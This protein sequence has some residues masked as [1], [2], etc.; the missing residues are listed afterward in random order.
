MLEITIELA[1]LSAAAA[2]ALT[3]QV[4]PTT[5]K[6]FAVSLGHLAITIRALRTG[7]QSFAG[8]TV[9]DF[10][11]RTVPAAL[12]VFNSTFYTYA[13]NKELCQQTV[14]FLGLLYG[15]PHP[16]GLSEYS[17]VGIRNVLDTVPHCFFVLA[18]HGRKEDVRSLLNALVLVAGGPVDRIKQL[19]VW[20]RMFT[21]PKRGWYETSSNSDHFLKTLRAL[22]SGWTAASNLLKD[23]APV[24]FLDIAEAVSI[25]L[26]MRLEKSERKELL[27][28]T[29]GIRNL[30]QSFRSGTNKC[31]ER[32]IQLSFCSGVLKGATGYNFDADPTLLSS[33]SAEVKRAISSREEVLQ[34]FSSRRSLESFGFAD[35]AALTTAFLV[36]RVAPPLCAMLSDDEVET[37][38]I[39]VEALVKSRTQMSKV[40]MEEASLFHGQLQWC[41]NSYSVALGHAY[42]E[43]VNKQENPTRLAVYLQSLVAGNSSDNAVGR[44]AFA[45]VLKC[46][47]TGDI[48][49][50]LLD[51]LSL[52]ERKPAT[53]IEASIRKLVPAVCEDLQAFG[54]LIDLVVVLLDFSTTAKEQGRVLFLLR[55]ICMGLAQRRQRGKGMS[56]ERNKTPS[57]T[58]NS[59]MWLRLCDAV[60]RSLLEH[61][62]DE[63]FARGCIECLRQLLLQSDDRELEH[64]GTELTRCLPSLLIQ[65]YLFKGLESTRKARL[66]QTAGILDAIASTTVDTSVARQ[67]VGNMVKSG[68]SVGE[69]HERLIVVLLLRLMG[70]CK[71][72]ILDVVIAGIGELIGT[73]DKRKRKLLPLASVA[74]LGSDLER[75]DACVAWLLEL[76]GALPDSTPSVDVRI[77]FAENSPAAVAKM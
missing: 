4:S 59:T 56:L 32:L 67:C 19:S 42:A 47:S 77:P 24:P 37:V 31:P 43:L 10:L 12:S 20:A 68:S 53:L 3:S 22:F 75:K 54:A 52:L 28:L 23:W 69:A 73:E 15:T 9:C 21:L 16:E 61:T 44:F 74:V 30:S 8:S 18:S 51:I 64:V 49:S 6:R 5:R 41:V 33:L 27:T 35:A 76:F 7:T 25:S 55:A 60:Q 58:G 70:R 50:A 62:E 39:V 13:L 29:C 1:A 48:A 36:V 40:G 14:V 34:A 57:G 71:L 46:E 38:L 26:T 72:E 63:K 11:L 66:I 45:A 65:S 17:A 2:E